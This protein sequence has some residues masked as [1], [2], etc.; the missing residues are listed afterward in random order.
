MLGEAGHW[1]VV[2]DHLVVVASSVSCWWHRLCHMGGVISS[3]LAASK[4]R[5]NTVLLL[6]SHYKF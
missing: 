4:G 1:D 3:F 6:W 5:I 2:R